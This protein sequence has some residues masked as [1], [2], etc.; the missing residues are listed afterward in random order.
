MSRFGPL[1]TEDQIKQLTD[2]WDRGVSKEE[3]ARTMG[4]TES[5]ISNKRH[6]LQIQ[7]RRTCEAWTPEE[8]ALLVRLWKEGVAAKAIA[9]ELGKTVNAIKNQRQALNLSKRRNDRLKK[10]VAINVDPEMHARISMRAFQKR[11]HVAEYIRSLI[12]RDL[13][14]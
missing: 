13:G 1:W 10:H 7:K 2:L 11:Q 14:G 9:H 6:H 12:R 5:A 4:K 3:I 8:K